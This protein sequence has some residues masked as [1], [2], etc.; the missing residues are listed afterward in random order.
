MEKGREDTLSFLKNQSLKQL[1][2]NVS[3]QKE[4]TKDTEESRKDLPSTVYRVTIEHFLY[5]HVYGVC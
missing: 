3:I 2:W 5:Y 1:V 4:F